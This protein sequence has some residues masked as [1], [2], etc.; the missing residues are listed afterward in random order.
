[1][2]DSLMDILAI[3]EAA[4]DAASRFAPG[5]SVMNEYRPVSPVLGVPVSTECY[6]TAVASLSLSSNPG[7]SKVP[8][9]IGFA[10]CDLRMTIHNW[11][12]SGS[13][14]F[15]DQDGAAALPVRAAFV[16]N[17]IIYP[18][19]F[20]GKRD[21]AVDPGGYLTTDP[22][23]VEV[24]AGATIYTL[25]YTSSTSWKP[26]RISYTSSGSGGFTA[27]TDATATGSALPADGAAPLL[28]P[29]LLTAT[30]T[31]GRQR[32]VAIVGDSI[33]SG[34][35]DGYNGTAHPAASAALMRA[36][37]GYLSRALRARTGTVQLAQPSD[38][39]QNFRN[40]AKHF[41]RG[42]LLSAATDAIC[43]YGINDLGAGLTAAVVKQEMINAWTVL[44]ARS[45][46]VWQP[47]LTPYSSSTNKWLTV[48]GQTP[49]TYSANRIEVNDWLR[50][51][52]PMDSGAPAAIGATDV[53]RAGMK[54]HPL[55][56]W[57]EAADSVESARNSGVWR[58]PDRTI[59]D[60]EMTS[61]SR[62]LT[63]ATAAFTAAD[64][65]KPVVVAGAGAAGAALAA[66]I[67]AILTSSTVNLSSA[68]NVAVNADT[69]VTGAT[70][71]IGVP[72]TD[73]VHPS[74][75]MHMLLADA[76]PVGAILAG[77]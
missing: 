6:A 61:G 44:A 37:G 14:A 1:M 58:A 10:C 59:T 12:F 54:G 20:G 41:R 2:G 3:D 30:P 49:F 7:T 29:A 76:V 8:H 73:G 72:S 52:A 56:S 55:H 62:V 39:A 5:G 11:L 31:S 22:L 42:T 21:G 26:N 13:S 66:F 4:A 35:G 45:L 46:R 68:S 24:A 53:L 63:S 69:S 38:L 57:W 70:A 64:L 36:G 51:G 60:G 33:A 43:E 71:G 9:V 16:I 65:Y 23:G 74:A 77:A 40:L 48:A 47:T 25:I 75:P 67:G 34:A 19:T 15:T 18:A 17:G 27:A 50:D 32:S 28:A